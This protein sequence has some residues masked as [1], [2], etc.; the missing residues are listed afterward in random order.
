MIKKIPITELRPGTR[1]ERFT[2]GWLNHPYLFN[3]PRIKT[4]AEIKRLHD[5]GITHVYVRE[6]SV[7]PDRKEEF[8]HPPPRPLFPPPDQPLPAF[9]EAKPVPLERELGRAEQAQ[10][11]AK[12]VTQQLLGS[13]RSGKELKIREAESAVNDLNTSI[14]HNQDALLLLMRLRKQDQYTFEHSVNVGVLLL[15]LCRSLGLDREIT[16]AIGLG[17]LLH[18]VGKMAVPLEI[19]NKPG[20]LNAEEFGLVKQHVVKCRK[21]LGT[22]HGLSQPVAQIATEHHER[23]DGSGYPLGLSGEAISQGGQLASI[24]DVFDALSADRCYHKGMEQTEVLRRLYRWRHTH[25][26][27]TL[28]QHFIKCIGIYPPGTLVRLESGLL[29]VVVESGNSLLRPVV[30]LVYD[31]KREWAVFPSDLDLARPGPGGGD[32]IIGY[33]PAARWGINPLRVLGVA[34]G[35]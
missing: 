1:I 8:D 30:R 11:R 27:E 24:A 22:I 23:F 20:A 29:A 7:H 4:D 15:A 21:I 17:G 33:E 25:F 14:S 5:W 34:T 10:H 16:R 26:N 9:R 28:V 3:R 12:L 2:C 35:S 31:T 18:D 13:V 19:L 6:D 32:R